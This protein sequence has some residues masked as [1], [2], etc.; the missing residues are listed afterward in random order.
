MSGGGQ[1]QDVLPTEAQWAILTSNSQKRARFEEDLYFRECWADV[2][3]AFGAAAGAMARELALLSVKPDAVVG[4]RLHGVLQYLTDHDFVS[5]SVAPTSLCRHSMRE[6]WRYDWQPYPT[7]RLEFSTCWYVSAQ[8]LVFLCRDRSAG[9]ALPAAARLSELKGS[10]L[11]QQRSVSSMRSVLR[12]PNRVLNF[13][14]VSDEPADVVRE[15]GI[16]FDPATRRRLLSDVHVNWEH[17]CRGQ[18]LVEIQRLE[19]VFPAHDLDVDRSL[20][21][22]AKVSTTHSAGAEAIR[23]YIKTQRHLSW[24]ELCSILDPADA[25]VDR[26]DFICIA[27]HVIWLERDITPHEGVPIHDEANR[28]TNQPGGSCPGHRE[29]LEADVG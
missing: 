12:P 28:R 11:P 19:S 4:R 5:V 24:A 7:D 22:I 27:S 8:I 3:N 15:L 1:P 20:A 23:A 21:R 16:Y 13:V 6:I 18:V 10:F 14:H 29:A 9:L 26:W 17:D 25:R 2:V